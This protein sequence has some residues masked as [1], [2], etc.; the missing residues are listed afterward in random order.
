MVHTVVVALIFT[1]SFDSN[2]IAGGPVAGRPVIQCKMSLAL[3]ILRS[4]WVLVPGVLTLSGCLGGQSGG[5]PEVR[6]SWH[7]FGQSLLASKFLTHSTLPWKFSSFV[8]EILV[9]I[10]SVFGPF[11][12]SS[13]KVTLHLSYLLSLFHINFYSYYYHLHNLLFDSTP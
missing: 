13:Q 2:P 4:H 11:Q 10:R 5:G 12:N 9:N 6:H 1:S 3:T 7:H 8:L